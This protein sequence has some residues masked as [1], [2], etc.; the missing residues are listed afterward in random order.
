[1]TKEQNNS[2]Y[3]ADNHD[4]DNDVQQDK[5]ITQEVLLDQA[6]D[7]KGRLNANTPESLGVSWTEGSYSGKNLRSKCL[8]TWL[9]TILFAALSG[10]LLI[11]RH[12]GIW[13]ALPMIV[14]VV[15][16]IYFAAVY[17]YRTKTIRYRL[18]QHQFYCEIGFF[19][20]TI[21]TLELVNID[22]MTVKQTLADR[23]INGGTG[24]ITIISDDKS[25]PKLIIRGLENP[26]AAF[27]SIDEMRRRKRNARVIRSVN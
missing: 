17:L 8:L 3:A 18:T 9:V 25:H 2:I 21:D 1:M 16:W 20:K 23:L 24:S 27:E 19:T 13:S 12:A 11:N 7:K 5:N 10:W 26:R 22:D 15:A 4:D 6:T 14:P